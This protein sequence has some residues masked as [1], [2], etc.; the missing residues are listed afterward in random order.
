MV[1]VNFGM[2][3]DYL[4]IPFPRTGVWHE[5]VFNYDREIGDGATGI[6]VPGS[7]GKVFVLS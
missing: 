1:V 4:D 5:W 6:Q 7:G 3:T 2:N